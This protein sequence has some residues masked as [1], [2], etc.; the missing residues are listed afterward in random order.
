MLYDPERRWLDRASCRTADPERFFTSSGG[1]LDRKPSPANQAAWD[2]AKKLCSFCPVL[3]ECRRDTLGE[4]YGVWGGRDEHERYK[5]RHRL[6]ARHAWKKWP[7]EK[8]LAWGE[9][10]AQLR[11]RGMGWRD[12]HLRTGFTASVCEG[13]IEQWRQHQARQPE[14]I[15]AKVVRLPESR[16]L[17]EF[18]E[19][20]GRRHMWV[21]HRGLV[22]DGW[23]AGE[24]EDGAWIRV[25]VWSGR[26]NVFKWVKPEAL[27]I[28][29]PQRPF[30]IRYAGRAAR[31]RAAAEREAA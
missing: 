17:R 12:I 26:G 13:L 15:A 3:E 14:E 10:L 21:R 31:E 5:E 19:V 23:Y 6:S 30:H 1:Q 24:T 22:S 4:E 11:S 28:Y 27:K 25:Q 8:R 7:E 2:R 29:N 18:P 9:H 20:P 16:P